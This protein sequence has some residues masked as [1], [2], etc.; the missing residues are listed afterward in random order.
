[1][2]FLIKAVQLQ[3]MS[4]EATITNNEII[5]HESY[6]DAITNTVL[7]HSN[8]SIRKLQIFSLQLKITGLKD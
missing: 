4:Q 6:I 1:M 8:T 3:I 2:T 5:L 7:I